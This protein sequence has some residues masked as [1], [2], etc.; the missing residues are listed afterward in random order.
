MGRQRR[1][2][3]IRGGWSDASNAGCLSKRNEDIAD[4]TKEFDDARTALSVAELIYF[5]G[6]GYAKENIERL[7]WRK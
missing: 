1:E 7:I 2:Y 3:S 5:L 6:F 4:R